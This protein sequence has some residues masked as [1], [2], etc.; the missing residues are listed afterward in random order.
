MNTE[1]YDSIRL[2][3]D[4]NGLLSKM[5]I[6]Y[7]WKNSRNNILWITCKLFVHHFVL[8]SEISESLKAL[9]PEWF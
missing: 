2:I 8:R 1:Y 5:T 7:H 9:Y 6:K 3:R 4:H